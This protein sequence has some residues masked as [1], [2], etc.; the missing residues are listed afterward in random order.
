[1]YVNID[2]TIRPHDTQAGNPA[3]LEEGTMSTVTE[4]APATLSEPVIVRTMI[5]PKR[6]SE[7]RSI[8]SRI[9]LEDFIGSFDIRFLS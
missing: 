5:S 3:F 8:G 4:I 6:T 9:R 7:T 1:V 2:H